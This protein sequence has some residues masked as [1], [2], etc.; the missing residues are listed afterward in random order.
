MKLLALRLCEHDSNFCYFNGENVSYIKTERYYNIKHHAYNNLFN[1]RKDFENIFDEDVN[2]IDEVAIIIDPWIY[3]IVEESIFF[4][5]AVRFDGLG[6]KCPVWRINH[7]Y[8]HA[9][10]TW[11]L[12]NVETDIDIVMDGFGD[13]DQVWTVFRKDQV[14]DRGSLKQNGSLGIEMAEFGRFLGIK[15][16]HDIDIAGKVMGLQSYGNISKNFLSYLSDQ[17]IYN[18]K[19][20]FSFKNWINFLGNENVARLS[21]LDWAKSLHKK[22]GE[23]LIDFFKHYAKEDE[24]ISFTGGIAHNV[25]WNYELKKYFKN[26][27]IPP[28][29]NDDGL[30][31]G[32]IEWLRKK[33]NLPK[34]NLNNFPYIQHDEAPVNLPS[35]KT[36]QESA[37][38]LAEGYPVG[39]YQGNGEIGPRALGN[40]SILLDPR[41]K[42]GKNIINKIKKRENYRPFGASVLNEYKDIFFK[43]ISEDPYMLYVCQVKNET[44]ESITHVDGTCRV[45]VVKNEN[46]IFRSLLTEFYNI[47]KCPVLLNTSMNMAGK[48]LIGTIKNAKTLLEESDLE[49]MVIGDEILRK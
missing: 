14:I 23:L 37:R 10:S 28:H 6:L 32:A 1:W 26:I 30:T 22:T 36:I 38:L 43:N 15:A 27:I 29:C 5:N 44:I 20:L 41:L 49:Y 34:F 18:S 7:H 9:L 25:L 48:P 40:R 39:W 13:L 33:N 46:P 11:M 24:S 16:S 21:A 31:L 35:I 19:E 17:S 3:N 2:A 42:N 4:Q 45:Q 47:T 12:T 8:A